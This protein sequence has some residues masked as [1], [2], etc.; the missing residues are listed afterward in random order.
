LAIVR[1]LEDTVV[2]IDQS[3]F[4]MSYHASERDVRFPRNAVLLRS[5]TKELG[6]PG[7]RAGY[8]LMNAELRVA[9]QTQR[10]HWV[11]GT[12]A[13]ALLQSYSACQP[14]VSKRRLQLLAQAQSL[15]Q[16]LSQLNW[17]PQL[18]DTP[19]FTVRPPEQS[20]LLGPDVAAL[21]LNF[22]AVAVRD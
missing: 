22:H 11:L 13:L 1:K 19:Y 21:L 17:R 6:T 16:E 20:T 14:Y 9:L 15:S 10:P 4:N 18:C 7:V 12:H 8:A 5:I 3:Y 2:V